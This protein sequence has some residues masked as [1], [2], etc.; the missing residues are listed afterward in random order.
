MSE[1]D[2]P[3]AEPLGGQGLVDNDTALQREADLISERFPDLPAEEVERRLHEGY[4]ELA[5]HATIQS[6]LVTVAGASLTNELLA[7][8][9]EFVVPAAPDEPG[10]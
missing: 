6:H 1:P 8:G 3:G 9:Q 5:E 10:E 4:D 7:E 2:A